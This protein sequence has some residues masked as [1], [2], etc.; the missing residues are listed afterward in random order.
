M[1]EQYTGL[2]WLVFATYGF[3]LLASGWFFNRKSANSQDY[4]LGGNSMPV[5]VVAISVLA[6]SQSAATFLGGP[7]Q[8]YRGD[9]SYLTSNIGAFIAALFVSYFLIPRF[10]Q[11]KVFR[12][13]ICSYI[14]IIAVKPL[15]NNFVKSFLKKNG[16]TIIFVYIR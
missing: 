12:V 15:I 10:Y 5:W 6:T 16:K 14:K 9:F 13:F 2:D 1:L 11:L 3:V 4:F 8:G 7:D